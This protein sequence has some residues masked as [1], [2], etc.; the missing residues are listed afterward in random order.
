MGA[1][2]DGSVEIVSSCVVGEKISQKVLI[3][4]E[5]SCPVEVRIKNVSCL[6]KKYLM[7]K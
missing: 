7:R 1:E 5:E 6:I 4:L 3:P 2:Y